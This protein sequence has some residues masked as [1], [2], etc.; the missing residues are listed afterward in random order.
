MDDSK[1]ELIDY[2]ANIIEDFSVA[3]NWY[4]NCIVTSIL[5]HETLN[6]LKIKNTIEQGFICFDTESE[7]GAIWHCWIKIDNTIYDVAH[8]ITK[9]L[10]P[11]ALSALNE[12]NKIIRLT[13]L[14][15]YHVRWDLDTIEEIQQCIEND[16]V[17]KLYL[18]SPIEYWNTM[19]RKNVPFLKEI[20]T[21]KTLLNSYVHHYQQLIRK[22]NICV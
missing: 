21:L 17:F 3:H 10:Y 1:Y 19:I 14:P 5:F 11:E 13:V 15:S 18:K 8:N 4:A 7:F 16:T 12:G 2:I 20:I 9:R 6:S 22:L